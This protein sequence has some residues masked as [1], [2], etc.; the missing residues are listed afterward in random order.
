MGSQ[1]WQ[2]AVEHFADL[3]FLGA[4]I[5]QLGEF[6]PCQLIVGRALLQRRQIRGDGDLDG[7]NF[8]LSDKFCHMP[9][10]QLATGY[11]GDA[12]V[13]CC[14]AWV[15]FPVGNVF[16]APSA[17][18]VWN[19]EAAVEIRRSGRSSHPGD[20]GPAEGAAMNKVKRWR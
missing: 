3:I 2:L 17:E 10:T 11:K 20:G 16:T 12:F 8:D 5:E 7:M 9:F 13:C 1:A 18:A 6:F 14:P 4:F 19:S 15:P